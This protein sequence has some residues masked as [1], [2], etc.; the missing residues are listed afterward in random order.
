MKFHYATLDDCAAARGTVI[1]IDVI[2][3]FS[4]A[5]Y[6][7]E[8]GAESIS[9]VSSVEEAL[10]LK[11]QHP[12]WLVMGEVGGLPPLGFDFGNSPTHI[13]AQNLTGWQLI[14]R[15]GA[16]TQGVVRSLNADNLLAASFVV[17][18]ATVRHVLKN[19]PPE[20][21]FVITGGEKNE[22][23]LACA[24]YLQALFRNISSPPAA[25]P[26]IKRVFDSADAARHL[27]PDW[28]EFPL[29]DLD[30]CT[31]IDAFDFAMPV[32]REDDRLVLRPSRL[33]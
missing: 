30:Y 4:T 17:A 23:D 31:W 21:T 7:F 10:N 29:S 15:T 28:P 19:A 2:R 20:V 12:G 14:Q 9:L 32:S 24:D 25:E 18:S 27:D 8:A 5:A 6:A 13:R 11:A 3:A 22:E 33:S 1:A 26:F 16:G